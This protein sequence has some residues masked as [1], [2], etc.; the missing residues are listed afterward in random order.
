MRLLLVLLTALTT[1]C[2]AVNNGIDNL[3]A[4]SYTPLEGLRVGLVTNHTGIARDRTPTI[5]L[6]HDSAAVDLVALFGPEHGIRGTQD[7]NKIS[8]GTDQKTGL[9]VYSLYNGTS[10][11]PA[12]QHLAGLDALVFDIQDIGTRFYTYISTMGLC[13]EAAKDSGIKKFFVLDRVNP[14]AATTPAGPLRD[15]PRNFIAHHE[16]PIVHAMT[17]G[18]LARMFNTE[19]NLGLD[20]TVIPVTG[21]N[22]ATRFDKTGLPWINPSPNM[23]SL[24]EAE[25]YPGV[26]LLE[27]TNL[28]VG[29]GTTTPFEV[30]GAP[31]IDS[32]KLAAALAAENLPGI[33]ISPH[34]YTPAASKFANLKCGGVRFDLTNTSGFQALDLGVT[35]A[36]AL[37]RLYPDDYET[38][39][40]NRLLLHPSTLALIRSQAPLAEFHKLWNKDRASFQKRRRQFLLYR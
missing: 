2:A 4:D 15:G 20:L 22:R 36:K 37:V 32:E 3:R 16:I 17:T 30:V 5:D 40:L 6:F 31:Y 12:P 33:A 38:K 7:H 25:L 27:F 9:P 18:E 10:R 23:R 26:G 34:S 13:M 28:S 35:L 29:R 11:K 21:W 19:N 8:D 14:I 39:N 24:T 1:S